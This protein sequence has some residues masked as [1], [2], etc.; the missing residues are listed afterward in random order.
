MKKVFLILMIM[1]FLIALPLLADIDIEPGSTDVTRA[2]MFYKS[3]NGF[4]PC[5]SFADLTDL[6]IWYIR[7][8]T[9]ED[10]TIS[11]KADMSALTS[12]TD[13][14]A[15][16][17]AYEIG[18]GYYRIDFP[19]AVFAA[20]ATEATVI[21][22]DANN[23]YII[24]EQIR[25]QLPT[26]IWNMSTAS[27]GGP[28]TYGLVIENMIT[29]TSELQFLWTPGGPL[30]ELLNG[31]DVNMGVAI[32]DIN[33]IQV[34]LDEVAA[35]VCGL[36][37][38]AM[39][40]T[41]SAMLAASYTEPN[42]T[43]IAAIQDI[44]KEGG[45]GDVNDIWQRVIA[46]S[47]GPWTS[48]VTPEQIVNQ[49]DANS[50]KLD[51]ANT[52]I[53]NIYNIVKLGGTGDV[54]AIWILALGIDSN[55][56]DALADTNELQVALAELLADINDIKTDTNDI[57]EDY[58]G[59]LSD[60]NDIKTKTDQ[61]NFTNTFV[62]ATLEPNTPVTDPNGDPNSWDYREWLLWESKVRWGNKNTLSD[63]DGYLRT[64]A[65]DSNTVITKQAVNDDGTTQT[66]GKVQGP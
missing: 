48:E 60:V 17:S 50:T 5:E 29:D 32:D 55:L 30:D 35:D 24:T 13:A 31:I 56:A 7:V 9:D 39:R 40:G 58:A 23:D 38:A 26:P 16:N 2:I 4:D 11:A 54:N 33:V 44:V 61:L 27:Y 51:D 57:Q 6:D 65:E 12:L 22:E 62:D 20:G 8:E 45:T 19:D 49:I 14:H 10:V 63:S 37:G 59:L 53:T 34:D 52:G 25:F 3:S 18:H 46:G 47:D 21:I 41:D 64:Y 66:V 15:D 43:G 36:D 42:N 1:L 28:G